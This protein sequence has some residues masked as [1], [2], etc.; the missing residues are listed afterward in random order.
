MEQ[1]K[2]KKPR[3]VYDWNKIPVVLDP[4]LIGVLLGLHPDTV[5]K[6]IR[7]GKLKGFRVGKFW[8]MNRRDLMELCGEKEEKH[9]EI[10]KEQL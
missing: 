10:Q 6:L 8:R 2:T 5:T 7:T 4:P 9:E 1:T 3:T